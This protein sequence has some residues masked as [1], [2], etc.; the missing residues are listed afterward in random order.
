MGN[1]GSCL[2]GTVTWELLAEPFQSFNCHCR[3]CQKVHGTPFGTYWFFKAGEIRFTS[4]EDK[5]IHY[6]SSEVL[7][8]AS[9]DV[10]GSVVPYSDL[11]ATHWISP[12]GC[13]EDG[14]KSDC[15]VFAPDNSPWHEITNGLP[16][17]DLYPEETGYPDVQGVVPDQGQQ[18]GIVRGSCLCGAVAYHVTEPIHTVHNCH[19]SLCRH[20]RAA[21]HA[22]NGFTSFSGVHFIRGEENLKSFTPDGHKFTQVFCRTCSSPMPR[23]N[24]ERDYAVIPMG[25][26]DDDPG[27]KEMD[28]IFVGS[29]AGWFDI[30]GDLPAYDEMPPD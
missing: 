21:A 22:T 28:N 29:K 10:C 5:I 13:H 1:Q 19:C 17:H 16:C 9:C 27:V 7:I 8:R 15:N 25:G 26:L 20:A 6:Q 24:E 14:R 4:G 18:E 12:G 11:H 30:T 2:C 23:L 3:M